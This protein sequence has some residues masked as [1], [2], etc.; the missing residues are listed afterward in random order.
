LFKNAIGRTDLFSGDEK[1]MQKSLANVMS[2]YADDV[3]IFPGHGENS[4][5]GDERKNNP[6]LQ[7]LKMS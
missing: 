4:T 7:N 1:Q 3:L 6:Y 2:S 5:I